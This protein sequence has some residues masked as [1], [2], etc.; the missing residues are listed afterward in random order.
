MVWAADCRG[1]AVW[2]FAQRGHHTLPNQRRHPPQTPGSRPAFLWGQC[3][4]YEGGLEGADKIW[5][6]KMWKPHKPLKKHERK[7]RQSPPEENLSPRLTPN[8]SFATCLL[9]LKRRTAHHGRR[10]SCFAL[11]ASYSVNSGPAL[12]A[13]PGSGMN[14]SWSPGTISNLPVRHSSLACSIFSCEDE[15]KFHQI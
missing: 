5:R 11:P 8:V 4:E 15:T 14:S 3:G 10:W 13:Y 9:L 7:F 6:R 12:R 2:L 1:L